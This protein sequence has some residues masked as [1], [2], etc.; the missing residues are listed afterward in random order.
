MPSPETNEKLKS[1]PTWYFW[2]WF[3]WRAYHNEELLA[4]A[5]AVLQEAESDFEAG[6]NLREW[7]SDRLTSDP[8]IQG[9]YGDLVHNAMS[10]VVNQVDWWSI[11]EALIHPDDDATPDNP[12]ADASDGG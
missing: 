11:A 9:R 5:V 7:F 10:Y 2:C 12:E 3:Q 8:T 6:N 1:E 4:Q